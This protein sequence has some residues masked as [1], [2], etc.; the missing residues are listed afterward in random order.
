MRFT[1]PLITEDLPGG[2]DVWKVVFGFSFVDQ[3]GREYSVPEGTIT[4]GASIPRALWLIAGHPR[5]VTIGQAAAVHDVCYR[6]GRGSRAECDARLIR[7]MEVL[8][9][10][11]AKRQVIRAGIRAGGWVAWQ[12]YRRQE[13][14]RCHL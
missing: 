12:R 7:G 2:R 3:D 6:Y 4:D 1:G 8:G 14:E 9:A 11:W 10:S 13:R 5:S